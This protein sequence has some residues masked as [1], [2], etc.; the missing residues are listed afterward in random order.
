MSGSRAITL[1]LSV[2]GAEKLRTDLVAMG[3]DGEKAL[4]RLDAAMKA[5][6]SNAGGLPSFSR[7]VATTK[8]ELDQTTGT[9]G[10][11]GQAIGSFGY[12][13]QDATVQ[14]QAGTNALTVLAQQGSQFLGV[15]GTGGAIAGAALAIGAVAVQFLTA[16]ENAA[17][18]KKSAEA[19]FA[20]MKRSGEEFITVQK[21]I[22]NLFL[23]AAARS[24]QAANAQRAEL[25]TRAQGLQSGLIQRNEGNT[26]ELSQAREELR[27]LEEYTTRQEALRERLRK[28]GQMSPEGE[29]V[30]ERGALFQA[31]AR[32]QGLEQ[33][34]SRVNDQLGKLTTDAERLR[35]A[36]VVGTEEYGPTSRDPSGGDALRA[37][38]DKRFAIQQAY[39]ERVRDINVQ[40]RDHGKTAAEGEELMA[41]A[42]RE[43]D[44]AIT[45]LTSKTVK[46]TDAQRASQIELEE[47]SGFIK[48]MGEGELRYIEDLAKQQNEAE[49]AASK[50][51]ERALKQRQA[52]E[53]RAVDSVVRYTGDMFADMM[54]NMDGD[55]T[56][57]W[58]NMKRTAIAFA[59]RIGA[60]AIIRPLVTPLVSSLMGSTSLTGAA[61]TG[62]SSMLGSAG[63]IASLYR[64][65]ST[66]GSGFTTGIGA[67]DGVLGTTLWGGSSATFGSSAAALGGG[68]NSGAAMAGNMSAMSGTTLGGL[69]GGAGAGFAAGSLLNG[70][71]GG[72][73]TGGTVGG[74][75]GSLAG[76]AI[77]S[78]VPGVGTLIGG[79][80][81]GAGG[82]LLGGLF[83][84][85]GNNPAASFTL[86][87]SG[88][89]LGVVGSGSKNYKE[90]AEAQAQVNETVAK[91]NASIAGAGL[92]LRDNGAGFARVH[93]G[94]DSQPEA[95]KA[96]LT[97][98]I[99]ATL[100]GGSASVMAVV[101]REAAKGAAASLDTAFSDID[102]VRTVYEPLTKVQQATAS[103]ADVLAGVAAPFD[104]AIAKTRELGLSETVLVQRRDE[105]V[106]VA[107]ASAANDFWAA[108]RSAEGRDYITN[109]LG[110]RQN[111]QTNGA[112]YDQAAGAGAADLLYDR[113]LRSTLGG[114]DVSQLLDVA[115]SL[116]G[117]DDAAAGLAQQMADAAAATQDNTAATQAAAREAEAQLRAQAQSN[118]AGVV[119]SLADYARSLQTGSESVLNPRDQLGAATSRFNAISGAAAA[120]DFNSLSQFQP[121]AEDYRAALASVYGTSG[122]GYAQGVSR[123]TGA[124]SG[125]ASSSIEALTGS[126][127]ASIAQ[128]QTET[129]VAALGRLQAEVVALRRE[130]QQSARMPAWLGAA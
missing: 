21:E 128:T 61:A 57:T 122:A 84:P 116:R 20:G 37:S 88:G 17:E 102:W 101:A 38:L 74:G 94:K 1:S 25:A 3:T 59:A 93:F 66:G 120:G 96:E 4:S 115:N 12:Q 63:S 126:A 98:S 107:R 118:A 121:A 22:N 56:R 40:M 111:W 31:R 112:N 8:T 11:A 87:S 71:I 49:E 119:V 13:L 48:K 16:S 86:G 19:A 60:E 100:T 85:G 58:A 114:L 69:L 75:V 6:A 110:V 43:R 47:I 62:G 27:R 76:A 109:V 18:A 32:V 36:G 35:N 80:L 125:V 92:S 5:A 46:L 53:E 130:G 33:D 106:Q 83:G 82:G 64:S 89:A 15:F 29:A 55:W 14:I 72:N 52:T 105:A 129:L 2:Q 26:V 97:R 65:L 50:E 44:E 51:R 99:L 28:S 77:G 34:I 117:V 104:A 91:L 54:S 67:I 103:F 78:I 113:Q 23:T 108:T 30:T 9:F 39:A 7:A 79:L 127:M 124:L 70:L 123:I 81:G 73:S 45:G 90:L 41:L 10:R 95:D 42:L 24:A 68:M